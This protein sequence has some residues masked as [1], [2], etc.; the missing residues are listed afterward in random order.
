MCFQWDIELLY[1]KGS[2]MWSEQ[3]RSI[4]DRW[5]LYLR[6]ELVSLISPY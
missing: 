4:K 5:M 3:L 2:L 1:F 6:H